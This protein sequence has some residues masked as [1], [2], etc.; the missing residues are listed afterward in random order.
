LMGLLLT[1]IGVIYA[2]YSQ[3]KTKKKGKI[4]FALLGLVVYYILYALLMFAIT[5]ELPFDMDEIF[6]FG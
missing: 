3:L 1:Y 2:I 6:I 4:K 5:G